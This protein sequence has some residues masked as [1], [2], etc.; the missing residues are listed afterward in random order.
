M[1]LQIE[2][3]QYKC[4][5]PSCGEIIYVAEKIPDK[6]RTGCPNCMCPLELVRPPVPRTA[7]AS[8]EPIF[9]KKVNADGTSPP[10]SCSEIDEVIRQRRTKHG[11]FRDDA[12]R[13]QLLKQAMRN[14]KNFSTMSSVQRESIDNICTKLARIVSGNPDEIDHWLDIIGYATLAKNDLTRL[15]EEAKLRE[16]E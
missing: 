6:V 12:G 13:A 15:A 9:S 14:S 10:E 1:G 5:K 16:D 8:K 4:S 7:D 3:W 2:K 11:D